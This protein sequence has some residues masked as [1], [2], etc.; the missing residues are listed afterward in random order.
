MEQEGTLDGKIFFRVLIFLLFVPILEKP[1]SVFDPSAKF[2]NKVE[3]AKISC[4]IFFE[5]YVLVIPN[6]KKIKKNIE[7]R[8]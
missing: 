3:N 1:K 5:T 2:S 7:N 6:I 4:N 8:F